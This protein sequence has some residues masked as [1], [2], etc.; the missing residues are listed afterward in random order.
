MTQFLLDNGAAIAAAKPWALVAV[1]AVAAVI[2]VRSNR[3]P[4]LLVL[5]GLAGGMLLSVAAEPGAPM[6]GLAP[7]I[8]GALTGLA[9]LLPF[10]LL[11]AMGAGD[12]KLMAAVGSFLDPSGAIGATL[13]TL[14]AGGLFAVALTLY[15]GV[16]RGV[17]KNV[18]TMLQHPALGIPVLHDASAGNVAFAN[19][20]AI[21]V[22]YAVA[23]AGGTSSFLALRSLLA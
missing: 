19:S 1:L 12:V 14:L 5:A 11:R 13:A 20:A 9:C 15:H 6:R 23:I 22:P 8:L 7:S 18:A 16:A 3:I 10:Y 17:L 2:D 21:R 4:N